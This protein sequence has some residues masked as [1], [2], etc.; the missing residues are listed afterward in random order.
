MPRTRVIDLPAFETGP[1]GSDRFSS[2]QYS[3]Q[4]FSHFASTMY[5]KPVVSVESRR[6][7][8]FFSSDS[9]SF[10]SLPVCAM[11]AERRGAQP[12][13]AQHQVHSLTA[14][15][16]HAGA[17][18]N[19]QQQ[20]PTT[21]PQPRSQPTPSTTS[22]P[23]RRVAP[24]SI[25]PGTGG[26]GR[27]SRSGTTRARSTGTKSRSSHT[28]TSLTSRGDRTHSFILHQLVGWWTRAA[29]DEPLHLCRVRF[30]CHSLLQAL[31][32]WLWLYTRP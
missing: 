13:Q 15:R 16:A 3:L 26:W 30:F 32:L 11:P 14:W 25:T 17:G 4:C 9:D 22:T 5:H 23:A 27:A 24:H 2:Q 1:G 7:A 31:W 10:A 29:G 19:E 8:A 12:S 20:Q 21:D 18:V 28:R 6:L